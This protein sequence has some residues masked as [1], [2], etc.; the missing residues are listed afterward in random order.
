MKNL[1]RIIRWPNLVLLAAIQ[2]IV[3]V[4]LLDR[5]VTVVSTPDLLL[6][7]L[8][9]VL[10]GAGGYVIND[11]YDRD[12]DVVNKPKKWIA[13]NVWSLEA[14]IKVYAAISIL[15]CLPAV[16]LA[17]RLDLE[18]YLF[19]YPLALGALWFYSSHLKCTPLLGNIW[20]SL[21]CAGVIMVVALPDVLKNNIESLSKD[22][23]YYLVFAFLSTM[24]REIV[25]DIED[26]DGDKLQ[27]CGS[28]VVRFG[29]KAGKILATVFGIALIIAIIIWE[30]EQT[31]PTVKLILLVLQGSITASL[32][33]VWWAKNKSYYHHASTLIKGVMAGGVIALVV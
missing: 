17:I 12:I 7:L 23:W 1:L 27:N 16:A 10:L 22:L 24:L 14:V 20:V 30:A 5:T 33:F 13:G 26:E 3:Y 15:G 29:L 21:F 19:I 2:T 8:T 11:F 9:T 32:G 28:A 4:A 6:L 31:Q 18:Q 25:K